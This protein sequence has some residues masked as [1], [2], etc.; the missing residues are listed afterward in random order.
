MWGSALINSMICLNYLKPN[1]KT[2]MC[3]TK[4]YFGTN[5]GEFKAR[6][7]NHKKSFTSCIDEKVTK[8]SNKLKT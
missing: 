6:Y 1:M 5:E 7:N 8:L 4:T 2:Y 3:R